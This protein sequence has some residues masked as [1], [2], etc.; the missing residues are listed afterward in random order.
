MTEN[1]EGYSTGKRLLAWGVL[2]ALVLLLLFFAWDFLLL[3]FGG[4]LFAILLSACTDWVRDHTPLSRNWSFFAVVLV[5]GVITAAIAWLFAD[6]MVQQSREMAQLIPQSINQLRTYLENREWGQAVLSIGRRGAETLQVEERVTA[7]LRGMFEATAGLIVILV[8]GFF[9]AAEPHVYKLGIL[10]LLPREHRRQAAETM[11]E[12]EFGLRW[13]L[14]GQL[15]PMTVLGITTYIGLTILGVPLASVLSLLTAI[16]IFVPYLGAFLS[17]IPAVLLALLQ[18]PGT[19]L[20]VIILYLVLH[21]VEA[22]LVTPLVQ[23]SA[24]RLPPVVTIL[25]QALLWTIA[26]VLGVALAA[27]LAATLLAMVRKLYLDETN[28]EEKEHRSEEAKYAE[29]SASLS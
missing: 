21:L 6:S 28:I 7:L 5:L 9:L 11:A 15:I 10:R 18:G 13:W 27:P 20:Q 3:A 1:T 17:E 4:F 22:Y 26:G 8:V 24:A 16:L 29:K 25:A 19:A 14:I 23:R 2:A 12:I